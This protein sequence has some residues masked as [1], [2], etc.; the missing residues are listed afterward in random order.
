GRQEV[1]EIIHL[2]KRTARCASHTAGRSLV[3]MKVLGHYAGVRNASREPIPVGTADF[4]GSAFGDPKGNPTSVPTRVPTPP[5]GPWC[6]PTIARFIKLKRSETLN[7][8]SKA[9]T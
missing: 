2:G 4:K 8:A 9:E 6:K 7:F 1:K 3:L 5:P